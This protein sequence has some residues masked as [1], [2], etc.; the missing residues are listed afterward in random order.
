MIHADEEGTEKRI[1]TFIVGQNVA[2]G[3]K[4]QWIVGGGKFKAS[5]LLPDEEGGKDSQGLLISETVVPGFEYCDHD[6]LSP[7]GLKQ[8]VGEEKAKELNW[9]LSPLGKGE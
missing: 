3:E 7:E 4:L 2:A 8:L 9:L 1:E 6:F 5:Y